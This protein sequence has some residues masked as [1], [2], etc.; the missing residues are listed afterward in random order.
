MLI[1]KSHPAIR[2]LG[3]FPV[4]FIGFVLIVA[5]FLKASS[6]ERVDYFSSISIGKES[7][8]FLVI[9]VEVFI[10]CLLF[11]QVFLRQAMAIAG[12]I[13]LVFS[14]YLCNRI[15]HGHSTCGCLGDLPV[16]PPLMLFFDLSCMVVLLVGFSKQAAKTT[17]SQIR[18]CCLNLVVLWTISFTL[19]SIS[20]PIGVEEISTSELSGTVVDLKLSQ[21]D[22]VIPPWIEFVNGNEEIRQG[23]W[24]I[25]FLKDDC[26]VCDEFLRELA[27]G[28]NEAV[29]GQVGLIVSVHQHDC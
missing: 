24:T 12:L 7:Q 20:R 4:Q 19:A 9:F 15:W 25:V 21:W 28:N 22:Q 26:S 18:L 23:V 17:N 3:H 2:F 8:H 14:A 27:S 13:F 1:D 29:V 10:G 5:S 16:P 6:S 11:F